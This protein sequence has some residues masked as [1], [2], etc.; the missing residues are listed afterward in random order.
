MHSDW[1]KIKQK[2]NS[3]VNLVNSYNEMK[4]YMYIVEIN[5]IITGR[6]LKNWLQ[7]IGILSVSSQ[8]LFSKSLKF[9]PLA[10]AFLVMQ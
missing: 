8:N 1:L 9:E 7:I 6:D 10:L 2:W 4:K 3:L 5:S